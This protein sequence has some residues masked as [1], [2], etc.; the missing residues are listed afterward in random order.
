MCIILELQVVIKSNALV[1]DI[2]LILAESSN[3]KG[4]TN[5]ITNQMNTGEVGMC[6]TVINM[7][8]DELKWQLFLSFVLLSLG[9]TA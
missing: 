5:L 6:S 7:F 4:N 9:S 1:Q 8:F 2:A 3:K